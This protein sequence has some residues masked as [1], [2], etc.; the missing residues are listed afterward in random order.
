MSKTNLRLS[1][2]ALLCAV[3]VSPVYAHDDD[4]DDGD[5]RHR[6]S[7]AFRIEVLSSKPHLVSG[8]DALV[9][10]TVKKKDVRLSDVRVELN[11]RN[12]TG[13]LVANHGAKTLTGVV[14]GMRLGDNRLEADSKR[15]GVA[16]AELKL[17]NYPVTGPIISGPHQ[18][19]FACT[20]QDFV[21]YPGGAALG[22]PLDANCSVARRVNYV[23]RKTNN[24]FALL[25]QP[26][27]T[28]PADL[29]M[30]TTV[31]GA[32][33]PFIM[34]LETGTINRAI[35]QTAILHN[36]N[37]GEPSPAAPPAAWNGRVIYPLG[38]GCIAGWY[39]QG[40]GL[41]TPLNAT[42]LGKGHAVASASLNTFGNNCNDLLSSETILM[43]KERF[44]ESYGVPKFTIGTGSSGGAYQSNQTGDNYPGTF[45]GIVTMNSFPD[46][47][48][49]MIP[50]H[51]SRLFELYLASRP[52]RYT[53]EQVKAMTGYLSI[54]PDLF[55]TGQIHEMSRERGDRM[56]PRVAFPDAILPGVGPQFRY[57]PVTNPYGARGDVYDHTVNVYGV[58]RNTPFPG[59]SKFAQRPLDNVGVQYGLGA[60]NDGKI[61]VEDF[62]D[63]NANMGG[64]DID[65]NR[66]PNRTVHYPD[67]TKRAYQGGRILSGGGGL[68]STAIITRS[69]GNDL[70]VAG[71]VHLRY[72]SFSIRQRIINANGHANNQVIVGN[73]A[74]SELLID[75]MGQW[76]TAVV[77]D[78]SNRSRAAKVVAN[79]PAD[80][81][82]A[83]WT[84]AGVKIVEPQ[85]L[86]GP[87][88]CNVLFPRGVPPEYVAGAP[89]E[90]DAIKCH[91]K[92]IDMSDYKVAFTSQQRARLSQIFPKGVCDWSKKGVKQVKVVP[93]ASFG[94]SPENLVFDVTDR[95]RHDDDDDDDD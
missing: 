5:R 53:V 14:G 87:G 20:T 36:P 52:G 26:Y 11:G 68:A 8:G 51:S 77:A 47:T 49:G 25:P 1:A 63:L 39:T 78:T 48:T 45:D 73:L 62:L 59:D 70:L 10:V 88:Q 67:A 60:M 91:L 37:S 64:V 30:T 84:T 28:P 86:Y 16:E 13:A 40:D 61:S 57:D 24:T 41:V 9:R 74:P 83:C 69:G 35:Y 94:P 31:T 85:V 17:T 3:A 12:V 33:V 76:L 22:A 43:V 56:D 23:Y 15:H 7:S 27:S 6:G 72:H 21:P 46:V 79:K 19:P 4:D 50:M 65:F 18:F 55:V 54:N 71:D 89:I 75:Q 82:D 90:L 81:V 92:R 42:W 29:A 95:R 44:I 2:C 58:I 32:T 93:F 66:V 34:R 80:V 38:G